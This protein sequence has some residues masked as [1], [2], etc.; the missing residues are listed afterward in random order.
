M[1]LD[2]FKE[3]KTSSEKNSLIFVCVRITGRVQG[4]W[5]R[6]WAVDEAVARGLSGWVVNRA[7]GSVEALFSGT[8]K[9]V[10]AMLMAC[11]KGPPLAQVKAV[12]KIYYNESTM[13][14]C[15]DGVFY[16]AGDY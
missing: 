8:E 14:R 4:V 5:F 15:R 11:K 3:R 6:G 7:D 16:N 9:E 13:P 2:F 1:L 12:E 10:Q